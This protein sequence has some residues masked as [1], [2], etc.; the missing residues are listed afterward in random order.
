MRTPGTS[1]SAHCN[2]EDIDEAIR[3]LGRADQRGLAGGMITVAPPDERSYDHPMYAPF[4]A[5]AQDID[6]PISLH[7]DTNRPAP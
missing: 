4:W 5:A 3:E 1:S 2:I 7:V 6:V